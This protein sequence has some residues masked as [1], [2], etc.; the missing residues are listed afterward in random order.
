MTVILVAIAWLWITAIILIVAGATLYNWTRCMPPPDVRVE[1]RV[2]AGL[3]LAGAALVYLLLTGCA[4]SPA[5]QTRIQE[6][7]VPVAVHPVDP[8]QVPAL[9][10]GLPPRPASPSAA[11]D[12]LLAKVCEL[13]GYMLQADPLVRA[14]A[15]LPPRPIANWPECER[16]R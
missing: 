14:G 8:A 9:V 15:G 3:A 10:E 7:A 12:L 2:S 13:F 6:V 1:R 5:I 4:G 16:K 11:A